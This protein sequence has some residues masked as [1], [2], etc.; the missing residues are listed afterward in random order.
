LGSFSVDS[1]GIQ[2]RLGWIP[3][4]TIHAGLSATVDWYRNSSKSSTAAS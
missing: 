2:E 3:P 4:H 1:T